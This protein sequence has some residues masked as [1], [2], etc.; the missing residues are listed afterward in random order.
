[1]RR[2]YIKLVVI[3]ICATFFWGCK[4]SSNKENQ[5]LS[6]RI[7]SLEKVNNMQKTDYND[8]VEFVNVLAD[9]LDSISEQE[10]VLFYSNKGREG[11]MV[12]REQLKK[13]LEMFANTLA[14]QRQQI[15][16]LSDSLRARG[17]NFGKLTKL[18]SFLNQQLEEK[19]N[20]ITAL[21][22]D[23]NN[24]NVN[25]SQL[26]K[27]VATLTESNTKL[28]EKVDRQVKALSVQTEMINEG[29]VKIGTKKSLTES[30]IITGGFLKK[31]K[32]NYN[33]IK[34]EQF[35]RVDIRNFT[36]IPINSSNP[37]VLS[38]MPASSYRID[39]NGNTSTLHI[40]DP[41][42]FWSVSNYL[43]IQT[44]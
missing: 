10:D 32:I 4:E 24:K 30:G 21:R 25:I 43:I 22:N 1:M 36:E 40:I 44:K 15:A 34:K 5:E 39:K 20:M 3:F 42:S 31:A 37:K 19:N 18:V 38:Q 13:N 16:R 14:T 8:L 17:E 29:Y 35:M 7:D 11:T 2:M 41:T 6:S 23:L 12:N 9:G 33:A 27:K 28:A 26:Q